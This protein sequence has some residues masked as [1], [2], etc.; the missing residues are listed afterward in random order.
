VDEFAIEVLGGGLG[1][2]VDG[3]VVHVVH[4]LLFFV[5]YKYTKIF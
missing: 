1:V 2:G 3:G 5:Q 4:C